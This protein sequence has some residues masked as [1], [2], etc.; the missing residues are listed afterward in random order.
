MGCPLRRRHSRD[1]AKLMRFL[2]TSIDG[3]FIV[4]LDGQA[5]DRGRFSRIF[6]G[7]EFTRAGID[8][9]PVQINLSHNPAA[10]TL[11]GMHSQASPHEEAKLV[12]CVRGRIFDVAVDLRPAS[13]SFGRNF[14]VELAADADRLFYIPPGCAHGFLTREPHSDVVY[15]MGASFVPG[16]GIGVRW[17]DP[18]FGIA[19]PDVP[20]MISDRDAQYP[21]FAR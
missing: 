2:S 20:A 3:A 16:V 12:H 21:D 6:C 5:D 7:A 10:G 9:A 11:R 8:F 13:P 15:Y 4:E 1:A 14:G 17:N 18:A 19:W